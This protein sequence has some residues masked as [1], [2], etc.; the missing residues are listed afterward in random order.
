MLG[1]LQKVEIS[2]RLLDHSIRQRAI[3]SLDT[4]IPKSEENPSTNERLKYT[5]YFYTIRYSINT[6]RPL[7]YNKPYKLSCDFVDPYKPLKFKDY[8]EMIE[9]SKENEWL[10]FLIKYCSDLQSDKIFK[11]AKANRKLPIVISLDYDK[12]IEDYKKTEGT[13]LELPFLK[14]ITVYDMA[15]Y[16]KFDPEVYEYLRSKK[17][18]REE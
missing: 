10:A 3:V 17:G 12:L 2:E 16:K 13:D 8:A 18:Y 1:D 15:S 14:E 9:M 5:N 11:I 6:R 7:V 4:T